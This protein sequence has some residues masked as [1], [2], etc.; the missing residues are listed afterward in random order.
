MLKKG[1]NPPFNVFEICSALKRTDIRTCPFTTKGLRGIATIANNPSDINCILVNSNLSFVEQNFHGIH[2]LIHIVTCPKNSGQ[3]FSCF[4]TVKPNQNSYIEWV[5]NEGAAELLIPYRKLLPIIKKKYPALIQDLG[6]YSFC[7]EYADVFSVTPTVLQHRIDS[8]KYE[9]SQYIS[10]TDI[11]SIQIL[12]K[13]AQ[14][15]RGIYIKSLVDLENDRLAS[16]FSN[17]KAPVST[18]HDLT[19]LKV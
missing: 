11:D 13:K 16:W 5:A 10:G 7:E 14:E 12:S 2:E 4:E 1:L 3:T 18:S 9:I 19:I 8:L 15:N 17:F 6:T